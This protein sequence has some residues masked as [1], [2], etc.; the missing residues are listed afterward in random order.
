MKINSATDLR[1]LLSRDALL[2]SF[3]DEFL[4]VPPG[5][6]PVVAGSAIYIPEFPVVEE[7]DAK[8]L[9]KI[10]GVYDDDLT[11]VLNAI[12]ALV[13]GAILGS[14]ILVS[15]FATP[16]LKELAARGRLA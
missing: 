12:Q 10:S 8:W 5:K 4:V 7:F 14:T 15:V 11:D 9:I 13:G 3:V 1:R 2:R 6:L 16:E